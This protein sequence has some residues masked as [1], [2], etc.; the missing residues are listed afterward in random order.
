MS[1]ARPHLQGV[2]AKSGA[3]SCMVAESSLPCRWLGLMEVG[4]TSRAGGW[5]IQVEVR[6]GQ[7]SQN[8]DYAA[9]ARLEMLLER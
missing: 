1:K 5:G 7:W 8:G 9:Q 4:K 2:T 3:K 6:P